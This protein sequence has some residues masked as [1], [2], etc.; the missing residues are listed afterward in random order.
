MSESRPDDQTRGT[1]RPAEDF[2][3][4]FVCTGNTCRSPLAEGIARRE[5]AQRGWSGMDCRSAGVFAG[6]GEPISEGAE[7]VAREHALDLGGHRS[8][9]LTPELVSWADLVLAMSE[10]HLRVA[11]ELGAG[12]RARLL[13]DFLPSEHPCHHG[14]VADPIGG[15]RAGYAETYDLL[16]EAVVGLF[17]Q[18]DERAF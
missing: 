9:P 7:I 12:E 6:G 3:L 2:R 5:A 17:R 10:S 4:L 13:T 16:E 15:N 18:L 11:A 14:P 8:S 1:E